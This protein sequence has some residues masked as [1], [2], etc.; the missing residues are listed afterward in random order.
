MAKG[1]Y[2]IG[3]TNSDSLRIVHFIDQISDLCLLYD[4][5]CFSDTS[6]NHHIE[7]PF[8]DGIWKCVTLNKFNG[9]I[10]R[11]FEKSVLGGRLNGMLIIYRENRPIWAGCFKYGHL[12]G[13]KAEYGNDFGYSL[14]EYHDGRLVRLLKW[15]TDT[16]ID[17][18]TPSAPPT[19][20]RE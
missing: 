2:V 19:R 3:I 16:I 13:V 17:V 15:G 12:E 1:D 20:K 5:F 4:P 11:Q 18:A 9:L 6:V 7:D 14:S 8:P 10:I